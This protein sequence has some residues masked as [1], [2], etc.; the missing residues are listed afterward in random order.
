[1]KI[2]KHDSDD[3][4]LLDLYFPHIIRGEKGDKGEEIVG[5]R[6]LR[7][8]RLIDGQGSGIDADTL[9]GRHAGDFILKNRELAGRMVVVAPD[10]EIADGGDF[11]EFRDGFMSKL[12]NG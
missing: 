4:L 8:I 6:L 12:I 3:E 1:M 5:E 7:E 9:D 10:G 11:G 2:V